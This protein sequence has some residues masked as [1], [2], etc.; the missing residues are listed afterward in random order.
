MKVSMQFYP[1]FC[2]FFP[3]GSQYSLQRPILKHPQFVLS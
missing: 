2:H 1:A 3:L